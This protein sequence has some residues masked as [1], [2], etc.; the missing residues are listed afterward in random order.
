MTERHAACDLPIFNLLMER[1]SPRAFSDQDI[2]E[3]DLMTLFEA[4]RWAPS[5][6]NSQPWHFVY[7]L[8]GSLEF[9]RVVSVLKDANKVWARH[10]GALVV[11]VCSTTSDDGVAYRHAEYDLGQ[12]VAFAVMQGLSMDLSVRQ[13]GGFD[14]MAA[15]QLLNIPDGYRP[16]SI[17]AI[18]YKGG[19]ERLPPEIRLKEEAPRIRKPAKSFAHNGTW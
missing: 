16:V 9:A 13:I 2:T 17:L 1:W 6:N 15:T 10:A 3:R 11:A 5:A 8:R 7:S 4:A 19:T 12:S 14:P 18:G